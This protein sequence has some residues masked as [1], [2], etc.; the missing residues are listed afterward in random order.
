MSDPE[1]PKEQVEPPPE[2]VAPAFMQTTPSLALLVFMIPLS[3]ESERSP[4]LSP[5]S[6][7]ASRRWSEIRHRD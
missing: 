4:R 7:I 1:A 5:C 3:L 6:C 2:P